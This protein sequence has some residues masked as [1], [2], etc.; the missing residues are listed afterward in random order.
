MRV[1]LIYVLF[2][3]FGFALVLLLLLR[4]ALY[5]LLLLRVA[6]VCTPF[7]PIAVSYPA[8]PSRGISSFVLVV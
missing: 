1:L 4:G 6:A 2:V 5:L 3:L 7:P 8:Y